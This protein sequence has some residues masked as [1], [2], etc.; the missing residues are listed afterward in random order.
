MYQLVS[1][2]PMSR[3]EQC[4]G[5]V[6]RHNKEEKEVSKSRLF[7]KCMIIKSCGFGVVPG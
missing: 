7:S 3:E 4:Q 1:P 2:E 5:E 6:V